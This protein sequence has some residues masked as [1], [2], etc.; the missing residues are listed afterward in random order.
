MKHKARARA[1]KRCRNSQ[2]GQMICEKIA[3]NVAKHVSLTKVM[4]NIFLLKK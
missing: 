4:T 3:K 1:W 2:R